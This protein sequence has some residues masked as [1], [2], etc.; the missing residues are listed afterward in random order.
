LLAKRDKYIQRVVP[1]KGKNRRKSFFVS[2]F[3]LSYSA[4]RRK[5]RGGREKRKRGKKGGGRGHRLAASRD[6]V[7]MA[8]GS[9][10]AEK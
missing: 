7:V 6:R 4:A 9:A 8:R 2:F 5:K 3:T 1:R 10:Y